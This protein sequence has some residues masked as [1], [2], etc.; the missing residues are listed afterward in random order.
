MKKGFTLIEL[1][2]VIA[3]IGILA[4]V[5]LVST[6]SARNKAS[7]AV[8]KQTL[9][10]LKT[11]MATCCADSAATFN[12]ANNPASGAQEICTVGSVGT[13]PSAADLKATGVT[14]AA[15]ANCAASDPTITVTPAG[16]P[17][18]ACNAAWTVRIYGGLTPPSGC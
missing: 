8:T 9:D 4:G 1:L 16:H 15:T 5:I 6:S 2:I 10:S 13:Y 14:Y 12:A 18:S 11:A 3:I 17:L 7:A